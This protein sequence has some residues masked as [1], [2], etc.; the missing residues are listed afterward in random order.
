[1]CVKQIMYDGELGFGVE[2]LDLAS[3][4]GFGRLVVSR[5]AEEGVS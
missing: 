4:G 5:G 1:M 3:V 2:N